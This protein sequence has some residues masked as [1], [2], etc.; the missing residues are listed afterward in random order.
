MGESFLSYSDKV[1]PSCRAVILHPTPCS[2]VVRRG[3]VRSL[4]FGVLRLVAALPLTLI[5][6]QHAHI[7]QLSETDVQKKSG[8]LIWWH[9][10]KVSVRWLAEQFGLQTRGGMRYGF[11][12]IRYRL[13]ER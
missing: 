12:I 10:T 13:A 8:S 9:K 4:F 6:R 11:Y 2:R 5:F 3:F 1:A 7:I